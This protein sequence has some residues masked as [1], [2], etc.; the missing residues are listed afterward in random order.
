MRAVAAFVSLVGLGAHASHL[1]DN[2]G[3]FTNFK[4]DHIKFKTQTNCQ[5]DTY[6]EVRPF[7]LTNNFH[8]SGNF[9]TETQLNFLRPLSWLLLMDFL[10]SSSTLTKL[11]S[12]Q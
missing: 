8:R 12:T 6:P 9:W 5:L 10:G 1:D 7:S 3:V 11:S 2:A 4:Y